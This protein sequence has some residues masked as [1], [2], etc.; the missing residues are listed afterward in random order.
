M[1]YNGKG[2]EAEVRSQVRRTMELSCSKKSI[3][4][5]KRNNVNYVN[6]ITV[7]FII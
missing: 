6:N 1:I 2:H 4:L 3:S 5:I 7:I